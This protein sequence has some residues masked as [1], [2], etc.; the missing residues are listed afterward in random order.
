MAWTEKGEII[1]CNLSK[2]VIRH[3]TAGAVPVYVL[4]PVYET[5]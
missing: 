5:I 4:F 3:L 1:V 2:H